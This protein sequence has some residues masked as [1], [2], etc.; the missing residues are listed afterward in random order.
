MVKIT[1][2]AKFQIDIQA[3]ASQLEH[4]RIQAAFNDTLTP[5]PLQQVLCNY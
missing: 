1:G 4:E 5:I 2:I 3:A